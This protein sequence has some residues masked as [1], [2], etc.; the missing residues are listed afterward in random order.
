MITRGV[1][2]GK[3]CLILFTNTLPLSIS[4]RTLASHSKYNQVINFFSYLNPNEATK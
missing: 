2:Q 1:Q 4:F 3:A